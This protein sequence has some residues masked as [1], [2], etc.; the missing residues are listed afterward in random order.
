MTNK[1]RYINVCK[2]HNTVPVFLQPFWLQATNGDLWDVFIWEHKTV[3]FYWV[4]QAHSNIVL[5]RLTPPTLVPYQCFVTDQNV[6]DAAIWEQAY[7]ALFIFFKKYDYIFADQWY[8]QPYLQ[9]ASPTELINNTQV[10]NISSISKEQLFK[11]LKPSLQRH[12]KYG[13]KN[14]VKEESIDASS[15]HILLTKQALLLGNKPT[16]TKAYLQQIIDTATT[17]NCGK[18]YYVKN[19]IQQTISALFVIWDATACYYLLGANN[20]KIRGGSSL[21]LWHA[22]EQAKALN[23]PL[24][25]FE[26]SR[27][28]SIN[29]FFKTFNTIE[30]S[31]QTL[32]IVHSNLKYKVYKKLSK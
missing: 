29:T 27:I 17:N 19:D 31:L 24:F 23:I 10:L 18:L 21:L 25:D 9:T 11:N 7:Q 13:Q 22:I 5:K 30:T 6:T 20:K 2:V 16:F 12:I 28:E 4:Y 8:K 14:Y 32:H 15:L 26:G 3:T 1:Q